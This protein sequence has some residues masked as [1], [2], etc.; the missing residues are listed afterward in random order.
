M[1]LDRMRG[2]PFVLGTVALTLMSWGCGQ[3]IPG[4]RA[5]PPLP[6]SV[7]AEV[8]EIPYTVTGTTVA[9]IRLSLLTAATAA[10]GTGPVGLHS[11]RLTPR[12]SYGQQG[13]YCEITDLTI[14]L[15]SAIQV[16]RWRD[17]YAAGS[18]VIAM[19]DAYIRELRG[20]EYTHR[21]NLYLQAR[22][23]SRELYR[24]ERPTCASM[25]SVVNSILV[26][27][28]DRYSQL[29]E[30]FDQENGTIAWPPREFEPPLP[31]SSSP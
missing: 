2:H 24:I 25:Q 10:L 20:H 19:W 21:E 27:I 28:Y 15:E 14:E 16:P 22:D 3:G 7:R 17:R 31:S 4:A 30:E 8:T 6:S 13:S 23:I 9:E 5:L 18:T 26:R 11:A 29:N 12:Y 1:N